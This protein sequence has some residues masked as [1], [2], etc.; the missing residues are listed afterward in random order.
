LAKEPSSSSVTSRAV[1]QPEPAA[2]MAAVLP[3]SEQQ[4]KR[5][6]SGGCVSQPAVNSVA[7]R[8]VANDKVASLLRAAREQDPHQSKQQ[9]KRVA[10]DDCPQTR[11]R[12]RMPMEVQCRPSANRMQASV[13]PR[14]CN[15]GRPRTKDY[16][17][18]LLIRQPWLEL[19]LSG[20]KTWEMRSKP[21]NIRHRILLAEPGT[22][23]CSG[24]AI[25]SDCVKIERADFARHAD[26]HQVRSPAGIAI[27]DNYQDIYAW[28]LR[29]VTRL[30]VQ[31]PFKHNPG[32]ITWVRLRA[33]GA[34]TADVSEANGAAEASGPNP[35][36]IRTCDSS[37]GC[38]RCF[39]QRCY[40][41]G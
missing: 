20:E 31:R 2:E 37:E 36:T 21:T 38:G 5:P 24:Q 1:V 25:I 6:A 9:Q 26:K 12:P 15:A 40:P 39:C 28:Q 27:I 32:A 11:K 34:N 30:S 19:I 10:A 23:L 7:P 18:I 8:R 22:G 33:S 29:D 3:E 17:L 13:V 14:K 35:L 4:R 41:L 16:E